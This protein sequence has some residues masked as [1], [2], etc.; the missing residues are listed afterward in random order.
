MTQ[1]VG[2]S[3]CTL[4]GH[5]L[6]P[7]RTHLGFRFCPMGAEGNQ[8]MFLF[9]PLLSMKSVKRK[10]CPLV[11]IKKNVLKKKRILGMEMKD[12]ILGCSKNFTDCHFLTNG[13]HHWMSSDS[14]S[15]SLSTEKTT[16]V[17][18]SPKVE[19]SPHD[20]FDRWGSLIPFSFSLRWWFYIHN[21]QVEIP[22][23]GFNHR[24]V[25]E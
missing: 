4:K 14:S 1:L 15:L 2:A 7:L 11:R 6:F 9:L 8:L 22:L 20:T 17:E 13:I 18:V 16:I 21:P 23:M 19:V 3:S 24:Q 5:K 12:L 10:A 25:V